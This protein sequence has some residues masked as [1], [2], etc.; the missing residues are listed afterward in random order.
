ME[1]TIVLSIGKLATGQSG[2]YLDQAGGQIT[3]ANAV[4]TGVE[5]YY[6][7]G[8]EAA[9]VWCGAG[10]AAL[11]LSGEV[12]AEPLDR[13]LAG[14][15]PTTGAPLGRALAARRPGFDLTFSAPKSVSALFG[16]G[17]DEL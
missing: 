10:A 6:L 11:G 5:D 3:R 2:Y 12:G 1:T 16:V 9:G 4:R 17:D 13:V 7:G 14:E 15:H 8:P